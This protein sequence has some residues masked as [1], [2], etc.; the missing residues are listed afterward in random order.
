MMT[1]SGLV[2]QDGSTVPSWS[3]CTHIVT[4]LVQ[5]VASNSIGLGFAHIG[6]RLL[7]LSDVHLYPCGMVRS[8]YWKLRSLAKT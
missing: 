4:W 1:P 7:V 5:V 6:T 3:F 2:T 8:T